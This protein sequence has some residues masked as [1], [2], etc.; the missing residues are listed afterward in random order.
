MDARENVH[1]AEK[2]HTPEDGETMRAAVCVVVR[3]QLSS[4]DYWL[5]YRT[6]HSA[7][8]DW[9]YFVDSVQTN[10]TSTP[11]R[12]GPPPSV[13]ICVINDPI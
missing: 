7:I 12:Q 13:S 2:V 10:T 4:N 5:H 8:F 9:Q 11:K 1:T 3:T 6:T